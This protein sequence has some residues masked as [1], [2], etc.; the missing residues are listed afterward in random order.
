MTAIWQHLLAHYSSFTMFV[1]IPLVLVNAT[2]Y[3]I[4][5]LACVGLD[6]VPALQKYKIQQKSNPPVAM[7]ECTKR[8][9]GVKLFCEIP[10]TIGAYPLL[11]A[12]GVRAGLPLPSTGV[13]ALQVVAF[14]FIEDAWHYFAHRVLHIKWAYKKIHYLHHT[15]T[16]PFG[17]WPPIT[18]I[19]S[20][21]FG[22]GFGTALLCSR[23]CSRTHLFTMY[24]WICLQVLEAIVVHVGYDFPMA[25]HRVFPLWGGARFHDRHHTKYN[26]NY[27]S[28][29][30]WLDYV[31]GTTYRPAK[32]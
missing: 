9:L 6:H 32:T 23:S 26:Y 3:A 18:P 16:T 2:V 25:L 5:A 22:F 12:V 8:L 28:V 14:F 27:A 31:F 4:A 10:M 13:I 7:W 1:T 19:R 11:K 17:T 29:F 20:R 30:V 21:R 24:L 15:Y